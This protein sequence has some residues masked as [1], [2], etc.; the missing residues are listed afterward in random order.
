VINGALRVLV[1]NAG[2]SS[3]KCGLYEVDETGACATLE[4]E[5]QA[6][7]KSGRLEVRDA[8][9]KVL[10]GEDANFADM[11]AAVSRISAVF[12]E[13]APAPHAIGHRLVHGGAQVSEHVL[14]DD[15]VL[16]QLHAAEPFAPLHVPA[17]L[18]VVE[19]TLRLYPQLPQAAC[20]DTAFHRDLPDESRVLPLPR[21]LEE[22]GLRRYGF[23]GLSCESILAKLERVPERLIIAH[24]GSGASLTAIR[25]GKSVDTSMGLTPAGGILMGTRSGDIDPGI[26]IWLAR[27]RGMDAAALE[28]LVMR[29]SGLTGISGGLSDMRKLREAASKDANA[30]LAVRMFCLSVAKTIAAQMAVL[31][32]LDLLV[33]TG[34]IGE[35][36]AQ[37]RAEVCGQ[38]AWTGIVLDQARNRGKEER[39]SDAAC[40]VEV[41]AMATAEGAA[42]ARHV[43]ELVRGTAA[44]QQPPGT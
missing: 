18:K 9:G 17:A 28:D 20:L 32:G 41:R 13:N 43:F 35:H 26:L 40:R 34:G 24:L 4:A 39:I 36:D 44:T 19:S 27:T 25:N 14:I 10:I 23:H 3:L 31:G 30:A 29:R 8:E 16:A 33:F 22:A 6:I 42:I 37:T 5:A 21:A 7:G 11:Q 12:R 38:L 2:S 15:A 1:Y